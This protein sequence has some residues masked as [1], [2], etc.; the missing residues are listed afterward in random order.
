MN[1][2]IVTM[3]S[4]PFVQSG[5]GFKDIAD[6]GIIVESYRLLEHLF[7]GD[8]Q[9]KVL[10]SY[11]LDYDWY[12]LAHSSLRVVVA[13]SQGA[14]MAVDLAERYAASGVRTIVRIG[15]TGALKAGMKLGGFV[16]P[17]AAIRDEGTSRFYI[18]SRTPAIADIALTQRLTRQLA[19]AGADVYNGIAWSTDG[20]WRE[21]DAAVAQCVADG[22]IAADMESSALFAFGQFRGVSVA[23]VSILSDEIDSTSGDAHKGL[24]DQ[25]V[26]FDQVLPAATFAFSQLLEQF[27]TT[28]R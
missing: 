23:S 27:S 24:S 9:F 8:H 21:T 17:W 28:G 2:T 6:F 11:H 20:R 16:L 3:E 1:G 14:P 13:V 4:A 18:D 5:I 10:S 19:A 7:R 15:T 12:L 22:A 25:G 26:W